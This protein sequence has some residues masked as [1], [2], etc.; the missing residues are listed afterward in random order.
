MQKKGYSGD[1]KLHYKMYKSGKSLVMASITMFWIGVGMCATIPSVS[2]D[3]NV[4]DTTVISSK[5][6][7]SLLTT[8]GQK[9]VRDEL[10]T[11]ASEST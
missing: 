6:F 1:I 2:A 9:I 8:N 7:G 10:G 11:Q 5:K 4:N 3:K